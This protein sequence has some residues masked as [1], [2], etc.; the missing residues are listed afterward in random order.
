MFRYNPVIVSSKPYASIWKHQNHLSPKLT[1]QIILTA[2]EDFQFAEVSI[3][4][5]GNLENKISVR[6]H[7]A[8]ALQGNRRACWNCTG[9]LTTHV[10]VPQC[11]C[12]DNG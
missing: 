9:I 6:R 5:P 3:I 12:S 10:V 1:Y 7:V 11:R 8:L 4:S 2:Y